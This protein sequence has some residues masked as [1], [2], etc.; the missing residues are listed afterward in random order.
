VLVGSATLTHSA[1]RR[2]YLFVILIT[3]A[4][5][6]GV[7]HLT[8]WIV[9][10]NLPVHG[11]VWPGA[12][13][14]IDHV[15]NSGAAFGLFPQFQWLYLIV[16][17]VVVVYILFAGQRYGSTAYRQVLLGMILGGAVSNGIDRLVQGRVVDFIDLHWWPV[18]NVA[19]MCIVIGIVL[20]VLTLGSRATSRSTA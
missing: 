3:A 8:K 2:R 4:L 10:Q 12:L 18:F 17:V 20:A 1:T 16:A 15:E 13:V 9:V 5:V 6:I 7:D 19:D 11:V 14:S